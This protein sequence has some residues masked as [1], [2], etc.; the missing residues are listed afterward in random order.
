MISECAIEPEVMAHWKHFYG[1]HADF[2]VGEGKLLC[3]FPNS[4]RQI[5]M[6]RVRELE[7]LG[8]NT[9]MQTKRKR[10]IFVPPPLARRRDVC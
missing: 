4:W 3:E 1:L 7:D 10:P 6:E 8:V 5:V 2:G 9:P